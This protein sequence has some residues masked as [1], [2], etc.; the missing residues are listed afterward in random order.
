LKEEHAASV[1]A[2]PNP[3]IGWNFKLGFRRM[4]SAAGACEIGRQL[5][6]GVAAKRSSPEVTQAEIC[7]LTFEF[8][9]PRS[10]MA[11]A[12]GTKSP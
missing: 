10:L 9:D 3:N 8:V 4:W 7:G 2:P 1:N 11:E 5:A 12:A 6:L